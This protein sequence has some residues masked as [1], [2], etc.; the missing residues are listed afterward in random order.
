MDENNSVVAV[1]AAAD[2]AGCVVV[3]GGGGAVEEKTAA[4]GTVKLCT[5]LAVDS[6][7]TMRAEKR[8]IL[9]KCVEQRREELQL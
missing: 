9:R 5:P 8:M 4:E 2:T 1:V 7:E 6:K 3:G